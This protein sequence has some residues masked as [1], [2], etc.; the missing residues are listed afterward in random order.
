V[1]DV[2]TPVP[3]ARSLSTVALVPL[4]DA[5]V[6]HSRIVAIELSERSGRERAAWLSI[7]FINS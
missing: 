3:M 1:A 4:V 6:M 7:A 2:E 5:T